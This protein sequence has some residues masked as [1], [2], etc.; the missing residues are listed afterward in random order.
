LIRSVTLLTLIAI[1]VAG[2]STGP[3]V[4]VKDQEAK[5]AALDK[6]AGIDP[7]KKQDEQ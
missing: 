4:S 2:C 3:E 5:K 1:V 7:S 6:R